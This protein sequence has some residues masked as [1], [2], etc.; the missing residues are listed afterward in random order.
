M[1]SKNGV[2]KMINYANIALFK[3]N[4]VNSER[5][6]RARELLMSITTE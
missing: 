2:D 3:N 4:R 1:N 6:D 5:N